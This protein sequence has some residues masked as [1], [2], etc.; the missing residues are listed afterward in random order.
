M[1]LTLRAGGRSHDFTRNPSVRRSACPAMEP[2]SHDLSDEIWL[3]R[4]ADRQVVEGVIAKRLDSK[5]QPGQRSHDWLKL[6]LTVAQ[7]GEPRWGGV[8]CFAGFQTHNTF[9]KKSPVVLGLGLCNIQIGGDM[10]LT[11]IFFGSLLASFLTTSCATKQSTRAK[12]LKTSYVADSNL[13]GYH[14]V[15][16]EPFEVTSSRAANDQVGVKLATDIANRL[17]YDFGPLFQTVRVG[18]PLGRP[19][20]LL[21][22]GRITDYRPGN[23]AARFL[24]PGIG[25]ADLKGVLV[26]RDG[27]SGQTLEIASIDKLWAFGDILG[28]SKGMNDMVD[29]TAAAAANLVARSKGWQSYPQAMSAPLVR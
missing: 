8:Y 6:P 16:V 25:K 20:E 9:L 21:V 23:R 3:F 2:P 29:E 5:Y 24:G 11:V 4:R 1:G 15:T 19:D 13:S 14:I 26:I 17:Q 22:T 10:K 28:V 7:S 27:S 12:P 18:P